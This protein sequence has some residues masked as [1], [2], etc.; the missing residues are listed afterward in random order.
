MDIIGKWV[1]HKHFQKIEI[2]NYCTGNYMM[3]KEWKGA[4]KPKPRRMHVS[5]F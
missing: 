1:K 3:S 4:L 2:Q 5:K